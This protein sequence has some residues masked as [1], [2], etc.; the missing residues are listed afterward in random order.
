MLNKNQLR[1]M[2]LPEEILSSF[3]LS[4]GDRERSPRRE[5]DSELLD[6]KYGAAVEEGLR[7]S[8]VEE[9]VKKPIDIVHGSSADMWEHDQPNPFVANGHHRLAVA[10]RDAPNRYIPLN[11]HPFNVSPW[12]MDWQ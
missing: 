1:L 8:I 10:L 5:T 11:H 7:D 9:G 2:A 6:R 4:E 3:E 12:D